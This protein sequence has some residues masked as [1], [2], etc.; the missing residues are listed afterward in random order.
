[1]VPVVPTGTKSPD[2][3]DGAK[4]APA[5]EAAEVAEAMVETT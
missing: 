5:A 4:E 1:M 2:K 3:V